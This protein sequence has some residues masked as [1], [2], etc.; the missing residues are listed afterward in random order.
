LNDQSSKTVLIT[1]ATGGIGQAIAHQFAAAGCRI[2]ANALESAQA[3]ADARKALLSAGAAEVLISNE[4]LMEPGT[5]AGLVEQAQGHFGTID[6]LINNAGVQHVQ[7]VEAFSDEDWNRVIDINLSA[8]FRLIR[9]T[10][11]VMRLN[12]WGRILNIASVHG[13]VA[14]VNKSAYIAAKHGLVGLTK[15]VALE[16]AAEP[17]TC[18]AICPGYVRTAMIETQIN[19]LASQRDIDPD[20][21]AT[22]FLTAKQPSGTFVDPTDIA[23]MIAFLCSDA[24]A[25]ITG[26]TFTIDGG[27]SAQ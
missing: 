25:Q 2:V 23:A 14:S 5:A 13:L 12:G 17:V 9:H 16:T 22:D 21:A 20:Q 11:P 8:P 7:P 4:N 6:I 1:G 26:S 3:I 18:N 15:A 10:L 19:A 27:W 24:G